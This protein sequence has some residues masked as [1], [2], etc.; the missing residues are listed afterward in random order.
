MKVMEWGFRWAVEARRKGRDELQEQRRQAVQVEKT[1]TDG[2]TIQVTSRMREEVRH[3]D[4]KSK[5]QKTQT[6]NPERPEPKRDGESRSDEGPEMIPMDEA[7][8]RLVENEEY[9]KIIEC[10]S[11]ENEGEVQQKVQ[12]YLAH[13]QKV[14]WMIKEQYEPLE[15][16]VWRAVEARRK[17]WGKEQEERRQ[18]QQGQEQS[19]QGKQ[20]RF[21]DKQQLGKTG[22]ENAGEPEVMGRT[23]GFGQAEEV[24]ASSEGEIIGAGR[25]RPAG[26]AKGKVTEEK[27]NMKAKEEDLAAKDSSRA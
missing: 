21:G 15:S 9:L 12:N 22:A 19:K 13:I 6:T 27:A 16:G 25:T 1:R 8:R 18:A 14:S 10:T 17:R 11:E 4:E 3:K 7:R 26:K 23:T 20:V 5:S 2:C 24:Q